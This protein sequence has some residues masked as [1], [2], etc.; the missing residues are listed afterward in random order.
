MP[1][2]GPYTLRYVFFEPLQTS[3]PKNYGQ[4]SQNL[5]ESRFVPRPFLFHCI[6]VTAFS[7]L[8]L[9]IQELYVRF[10]LKVFLNTELIHSLNKYLLN[11]DCALGLEN[12][13]DGGTWWAAVHEVT[14]SRT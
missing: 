9:L 2:G 13:M 6:R 14:K 10:T 1:R 7:F 8:Q 4:P 5:L 3:T 12:P 11:I